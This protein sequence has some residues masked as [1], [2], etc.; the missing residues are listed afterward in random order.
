[1][2][3]EAQ[4]SAGSIVFCKKQLSCIRRTT[5]AE[6]FKHNECA[7]VALRFGLFF[8]TGTIMISVAF[9]EQCDDYTT[10]KKLGQQDKKR[11]LFY[12]FIHIL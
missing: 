7:F 11:D 2:K 9:N 3:K 1:M 10:V 8:D 4:N 5:G 6:A 12:F